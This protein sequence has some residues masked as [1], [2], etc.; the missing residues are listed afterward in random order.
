MLGVL[1]GFG[2]FIAA[3]F[4]LRRLPE[5]GV[6][7][8]PF[9][10]DRLGEF[11]TVIKVDERLEGG[12]CTGRIRVGPESWRAIFQ[13]EPPEVGQKVR[14]VGRNNLTLICAPSSVEA[15][16]EAPGPRNAALPRLVAGFGCVAAGLLCILLAVPAYFAIRSAP[17]AVGI[18]LFG[19]LA[20]LVC[21][22]GLICVGSLRSPNE[23]GLTVRG[24]RAVISATCGFVAYTAISV[25]VAASLLP[26]AAALVLAMFDPV[27]GEAL[28]MLM[29]GFGVSDG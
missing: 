14:I 19:L 22:L 7:V 15:P 10:P 24:L 25:S 2:V 13:Q 9:R 11:A 29:M 21:V 6:T 26:V 20:P 23:A 5:V 12:H 8:K 4:F 27:L 18:G 28:A 16:D 17:S 3:L 1:A